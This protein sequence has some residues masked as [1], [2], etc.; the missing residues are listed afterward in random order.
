MADTDP[1]TV[2]K[3]RDH[4][5]AVINDRMAT[6]HR[7]GWL[8]LPMALFALFAAGGGWLRISDHEAKIASLR[9]EMRDVERVSIRSEERMATMA[10]ILREMRDEQRQTRLLIQGHIRAQGATP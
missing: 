9:A 1:T 6:L 3:N 8:L 4:L 7:L 5:L 2:Y 10:D